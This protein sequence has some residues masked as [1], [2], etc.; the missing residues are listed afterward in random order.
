MNYS[1][2]LSLLL[3]LSALSASELELQTA[4]LPLYV[5][6]AVVNEGV[7]AVHAKPRKVSFISRG[8]QPETTLSFLNR[9]FKP[10]HDATW[11]EGKNIT[12]ANLI[13]M[14]GIRLSQSSARLENDQYELKITVDT[15]VFKLPDGVD[16]SKEV[17]IDLI[18]EAITL[19][20]PGVAI[21]L[22]PAQ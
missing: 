20:Y 7:E 9:A 19:N 22:V 15:S 12:D 8:A 16:L 14:C 2:A 10:S 4:F 1:I 21:T 5:K 11:H 18:L 13:S 3:P 6:H 17:A